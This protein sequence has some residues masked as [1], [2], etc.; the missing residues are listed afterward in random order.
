MSME[1]ELAYGGNKIKFSLPEENLLGVLEARKMAALPDPSTGI[2]RAL[3][4]PIASAPLSQI[5]KPGERV[6]II[7]S[8]KT[9]PTRSDLFLPVLLDELNSIGVPDENI[10]VVFATGTHPGHTREEQEVIVGKDV[11]QRIALY[12]HDAFEKDGHVY[13]GTTSRGT[14]VELNRRVAEA[15]RIILTGAIVYHYFAGF[16]GGRKGIAPGVV[17]AQ[18]IQSNHRLVLNPDGGTNPLARTGISEGNPVHEDMME[19]AAL[20]KPDF[21]CNTVLNDEGELAAVFAGHWR[22]AH[23]AG[24]DYID[25]HY[26]VGIEREADLVVVS[27]GGSSK[28]LNFVQSHKAI[29]N[30]AYALREGGVMIILAECREGFVSERYLRWL[31]YDSPEAIEAVLREEFSIPGHTM[32]SAMKK[33]QKFSIFLLSTL[34]EN[35]V[36]RMGMIPISSLDDAWRMAREKVGDSPSTYVIPQG[37]ITF[38]SLNAG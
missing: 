27:A 18:T 15:D 12:D 2:E 11:A 31:E 29:D 17:S 36:R 37:Y 14:R 10:F 38:P 8:D 24:C 6:A 1:F 35:H 21:L 23:R 33:A 5:V 30:A 19:I 25:K 20:V 32:Y 22:E 16:S 28:D 13:V 4:T 3:R 34:N 7:V 9:R 26:K